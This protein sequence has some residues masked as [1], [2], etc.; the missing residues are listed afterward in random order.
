MPVAFNSATKA[1]TRG[2]SHQRSKGE[3]TNARRVLVELRAVR[4]G[5]REFGMKVV[6]RGASFGAVGGRGM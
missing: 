1:W 2:S 4:R 3:R 5:A 6:E